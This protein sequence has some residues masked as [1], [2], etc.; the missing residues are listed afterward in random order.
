LYRVG[1]GG[2]GLSLPNFYDPIFYDPLRSLVAPRQPGSSSPVTG[3]KRP[4]IAQSRSGETASIQMTYFVTL[5]LD[6]LVSPPAQSWWRAAGFSEGRGSAWRC[7]QIR[8]TAIVAAVDSEA[9]P[10][11]ATPRSGLVTP[12]LLPAIKAFADCRGQALARYRL[13]NKADARV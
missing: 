9:H 7:G 8:P 4:S 6:H 10:D 11:H 2:N 1:K 12:S 3:L 13:L 5:T